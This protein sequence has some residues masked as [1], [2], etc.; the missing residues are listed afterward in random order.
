MNELKSKGAFVAGAASKVGKDHAPDWF[1]QYPV[2]ST[3]RPAYPRGPW[4]YK[5]MHQLVVT[6][7]S[8]AEAVR[9]VLPEPLQPA[10]GNRVTME[11]RHMSEVSGFGPYTEVG[12]SVACTFEGKPAIYVFQAFLNSESPTLAGR[13]ILGF[14]KRHGEP[15]LKTVREVL[16]GTLAYGGVQVALATMPYRTVDLSHRLAEIEQELQTTQL[17]LKL[18]PDVDNHTPKVAQLV[19]VGIYNVRLKGAWG[20]PAELFMVPHVGC[21][22]AALPVVRV[23]EGRQHLWDMTLNDGHVVHD[24]LEAER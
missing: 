22:V 4:H 18:L 7:E 14:P 23:L 21:P 2:M 13:E 6:Y 16:T 12:H 5:D 1:L 15:E 8:T 17:V 20:G 19:Q 11:W 24:Y 10:E 3:L 9:A